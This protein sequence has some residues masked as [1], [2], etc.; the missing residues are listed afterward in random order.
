MSRTPFR[1][2]AR[3]LCALA[4]AL[5]LSSS[6]HAAAADDDV[7]EMARQ[8]F[9][10]GVQFFDQR[11]Y[12]KA[13][14]AFLQ[15]YAIKP[16][17]ATLLNLAQSELRA[18][19]PDDAAG[20]FADYLRTNTS[21]NE[22]EKQEAELGFTAAKAKVGEVTV[23]VDASGAQV[24][25]DGQEKGTSP[26]P[27]PLYLSPGN[28]ALEARHNDRN[29]TKNIT[30]TAGQAVSVNLSFRGAAAAAAAPPAAGGPAPEGAAAPPPGE[31]GAEPGPA[32]PEQE[33]AEI[34]TGGRKPFF[35]WLFST[36]GA[37][38]LAGA[39]VLSLGASLGTG[40]A[41]K[42]S[43]DN[44]AQL[45]TP[46]LGQRD[47][48]AATT[49]PTGKPKQPLFG[50]QETTDPN[51]PDNV[52]PCGLTQAQ[53]NSVRALNPQ[54][55]NEYGDACSRYQDNVNSGDT[56]KTVAI[57]TGVVG[58]AAIVGTVVYYFLDSKQAS[59]E[60]SGSNRPW[61]RVTP[62]GLPGTGNGGIA[63]VG[64]F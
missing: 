16:H 53:E 21:A 57:V 38:V 46:I 25:V 58:G 3:L 13:R 45:Q 36:P 60:A 35:K 49:D 1:F 50:Q 52:R 28:H 12:E 31:E 59:T 32:A 44:A 20:H 54:R 56:L 5:A 10:E 62:W 47:L 17:Q 40:L 19:H 39:G 48:D 7:T 24:S 34:T 37:I 64:Q 14:L 30:V 51:Y 18:G 8:R 33:P 2:L 43:Y 42:H 41:S 11:Q 29:V 22:S 63:I 15:S 61:A 26:L 6:R 55:L 23:A 27:G 4:V 9:R